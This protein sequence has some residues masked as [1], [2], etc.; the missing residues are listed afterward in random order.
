MNQ[1]LR[2]VSE[3]PWPRLLLIKTITHGVIKDDEL[4]EEISIDTLVPFLTFY[5]PIEKRKMRR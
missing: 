4:Y 1:L 5:A 3:G 2:Q